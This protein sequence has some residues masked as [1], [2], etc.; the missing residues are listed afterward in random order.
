M[1]DVMRPFIWGWTAVVAVGSLVLFALRYG[2]SEVGFEDAGYY[3]LAVLY[4]ALGSLIVVRQDGQRIGWLLLAFGAGG[5]L[6]ALSQMIIPTEPPE[7]LSAVLALAVMWE[8]LGWWIG[9]LLPL[10]LLLFLFPTGRFPSSRWRW[11]GVVAAVYAAQAVVSAVFS[12]E[13]TPESGLWTVANPIGFLPAADVEESPFWFLFGLELVS[14]LVGGIAAIVVRYRRATSLVRTQIK[15]VV[16]ATTMF[17]VAL[18]SG[19]F[20]PDL[21][22][23]LYSLALV[24]SLYFIPISITIAIARY[25]LFEI[26]RII[27]RTVGYALVILTLGVVYVAGAV[28]LPTQLLGEQPP[29]FV[30][31]ST[32]VAAALFSPVRRRVLRRVDRRFHRSGYEAERVV[33]RLANHLQEDVEV[34]HLTENLESVVRETMQPSAIGVWLPRQRGDAAG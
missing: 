6:S 12:T 32:L 23:G 4:T 22:P 2:G 27:S 10:F 25:R 20:V 5:L 8:S 31:G 17:A 29:L 26:D 3:G 33:G 11:A 13:L 34:D 28:W 30:A 24:V 16:F 15:W 14:L 18:A 9:L 21:L 19:L 7:S 1:H